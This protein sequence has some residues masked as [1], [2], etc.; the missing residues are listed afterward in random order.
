MNGIGDGGGRG[1][2]G[3]LADDCEDIDDE[4]ADGGI[5]G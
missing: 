3:E 5:V 2:D 4:E 1:G